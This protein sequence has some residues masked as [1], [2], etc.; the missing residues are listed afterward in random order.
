MA[1]RS[2]AGGAA[3]TTITGG[4]GATDLT[5]T[6]ADATG[7][8]NTASGECFV[9]FERGTANE[10][11][12]L[13]TRSG[14]TLTFASTGKRGLEGTT[15][16]AHSS[17][18][19]IEH[20]FSETDADEAN[21]HVNST[22]GVHG[23]TGSVVGTSDTQTLSNKTVNLG[24]NTVTGTTAQFNTALSDGDFATL[25][26]T[27]TLTNK[28]LNG[29]TLNA[30]STIGGVSGTD[31]AADRTAWTSFTPTWTSTASLPVCIRH[32]HGPTSPPG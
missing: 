6:I 9:T 26:G 25:A 20:T 29:A 1:R 8:P 7:W 19:S 21:E 4:I 16:V 11:R 5:V 22:S 10:E 30:A 32:I 18:S 23:V 3:A 13:C 15:A 14:T 27:E 17:G 31:L 24:S 12:A 28:T 2:Y